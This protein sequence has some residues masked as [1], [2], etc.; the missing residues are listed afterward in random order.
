MKREEIARRVGWKYIAWAV[1]VL[2]IGSLLPQLNKMVVTRQVNDL[3]PLAFWIIFA[4]Q[5][6][7]CADGFLKRNR[8]LMVCMGLASLI[9]LAI[10]VLYYCWR[11]TV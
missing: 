7:Y 1:C 11:I 6:I 3:S 5:A 4:N 9:T 8:M 10:I 2:G